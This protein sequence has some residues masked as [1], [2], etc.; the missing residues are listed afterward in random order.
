VT[1]L[2]EHP[3]TTL[4]YIIPLAYR[5]FFSLM[6]NKYTKKLVLAYT[7]LKNFSTFIDIYYQAL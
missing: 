4:K 5:L 1:S 3:T 2:D 6:A 7:V